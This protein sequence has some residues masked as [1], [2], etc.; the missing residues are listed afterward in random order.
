MEGWQVVEGR[1]V[2]VLGWGR[3]NCNSQKATQSNAAQTL[4][5]W[6]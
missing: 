1:F 3:T 5:K 4:N 2:G 6:S